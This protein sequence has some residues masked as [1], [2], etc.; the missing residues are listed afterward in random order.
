MSTL[1]FGCRFYMLAVIILDRPCADPLF[2]P[3]KPETERL[4]VRQT[5]LKAQ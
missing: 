3:L 1:L 2:I 5:W 4:A